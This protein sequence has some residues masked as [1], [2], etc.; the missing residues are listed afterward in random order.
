MKKILT[1]LLCLF[2]TLTCTNVIKADGTT[3][4]VDPTGET[5]GAYERLDLAAAA[6][7]AEG[8]TIVIKSD[9]DTSL[10]SSSPTLTAT[11]KITI[12]GESPSV[13]LTQKRAL[14]AACEVEIDNLT[15]V[16]GALSSVD[17]IYAQ[18]N[19]LTIGRNVTKSS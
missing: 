2:M 7:P 4:Y 6:L 9:A 12:V 15:L 10:A 8:G 13:R 18:G 17:F 5:E 1:M 14:I 3:V 19:N 16:N 11:G